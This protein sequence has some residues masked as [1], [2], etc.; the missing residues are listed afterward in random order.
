MVHDGVDISN[1]A[2]VRCDLDG[3]EQVFFGSPLGRRGAFLLKLSQIPDIVAARVSF[4]VVEFKQWLKAGK[5]TC[6]SQC[7][8]GWSLW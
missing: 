4:G 7:P 1:D 6:R 3:A 2:L 5:L 8:R